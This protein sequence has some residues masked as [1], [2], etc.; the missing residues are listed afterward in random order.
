MYRGH[1]VEMAVSRSEEAVE[2]E[3]SGNKGE[4]A[5][6]YARV[7]AKKGQRAEEHQK[8]E[9]DQRDPTGFAAG[10]KKEALDIA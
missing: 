1:R 3:G 2:K 10:T 4:R 6:R 8:P 7:A 9:A 5:E